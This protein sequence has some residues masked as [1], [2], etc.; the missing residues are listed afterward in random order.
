MPTPIQ[1]SSI[2]NKLRSFFRLRGRQIFTLDE[3]SV[4]TVQI[5]DLTNAPY[6]GN[7][8]V[9]WK[10]GN[11]LDVSILVGRVFMVVVNTSRAVVM[12]LAD[13]PGVAVIEEMTLQI[14]GAAGMPPDTARTWLFQ[15]I[16][17]QGFL[18]SV[19]P[20]AVVT[21]N[22]V[23]VDAAF[24]TPVPSLGV[25]GEVPIRLNGVQQNIAPDLGNTLPLGLGRIP[26]DPLAAGEGTGD[27]F[28]V[29][30]AEQV[31]I[32]DNVAFLATNVIPATAGE[33]IVSVSGSYYPLARS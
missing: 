27:I 20:G 23:N 2:T 21:A 1:N 31:T 32:G 26:N 6:R 19:E 7:D 15:L 12:D 18:Q 10:V 14:D 11:R 16:H 3:T 5:E 8:Q 9:R 30:L 22:G 33:L 28:R 13:V 17:H 24:T 25:L 4:P 29:I